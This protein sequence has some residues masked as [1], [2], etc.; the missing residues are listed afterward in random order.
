[1]MFMAI[2]MVVQGL[3]LKTISAE[4]LLGLKIV[5]LA[6]LYPL[7]L[8]SEKPVSDLQPNSC[9]QWFQFLN[10]TLWERQSRILWVS[11]DELEGTL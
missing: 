7:F 9:F 6:K 1:M 8:Y 5:V 11:D 3:S 10:S 4:K 2:L